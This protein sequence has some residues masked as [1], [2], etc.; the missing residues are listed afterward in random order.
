LAIGLVA[1][2]QSGT[3]PTA[4]GPWILGAAILGMLGYVSLKVARRTQ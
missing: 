2:L 3:G 4:L 1:S